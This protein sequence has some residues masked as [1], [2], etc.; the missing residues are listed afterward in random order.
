[1]HEGT[2]IEDNCSQIFEDAFYDM[3]LAKIEK[4]KLKTSCFSLQD[5]RVFCSPVF[6]EYVNGV[7]QI[8]ISTNVDLSSQPIYEIYVEETLFFLIKK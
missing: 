3:F 4:K 1:L 8:S 6:D 5:T 2:V 7:E